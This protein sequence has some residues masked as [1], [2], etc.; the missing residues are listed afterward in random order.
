MGPLPV[1]T[2]PREA[3]GD[4]GSSEGRGA[5]AVAHVIP[6]RGAHSAALHVAPADAQAREASDAR[7]VADAGVV[8]PGLCNRGRV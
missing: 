6:L 3:A 4:A 7:S 1:V 2:A 8:E 5:G